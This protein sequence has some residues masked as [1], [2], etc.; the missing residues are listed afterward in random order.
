VY[1]VGATLSTNF[2]A[3]T[4]VVQGSCGNKILP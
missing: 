2:P 3:T 4:G 1:V